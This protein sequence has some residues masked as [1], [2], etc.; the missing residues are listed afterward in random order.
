MQHSDSIILNACTCWGFANI[1]IPW[2]MSKHTFVS[3]V[4]QYI[5]R[6]GSHSKKL[7]KT[8]EVAV[9]SDSQN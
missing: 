2:P 9:L 3:Y 6:S 1:C 8:E 5:W 7:Q 4:E